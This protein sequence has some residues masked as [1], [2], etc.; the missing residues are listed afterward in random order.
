VLSVRE[1]RGGLLLAEETT[2]PRQIRDALKRIDPDLILGQEVDSA[3][4]CFVWKVLLRRGDRPAEWL[5][6]WREDPADPRSRP[7]P[8]SSALLDEVWALRRGSRRPYADPLK[9]NDEM[10]EQG[11]E[12]ATEETLGIS[13]EVYKRSRR[14][15]PV[16]RSRGLYLARA[17]ARREG[18]S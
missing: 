6:D 2:A 14:L 1:T 5:L 3:W 4:S 13:R 9:A 10:V 18:K 8:L 17:R 12:E 16:Q 7:R 15:S 11:D